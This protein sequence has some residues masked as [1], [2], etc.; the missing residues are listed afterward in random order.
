M[1]GSFPIPVSMM[2]LIAT[3]LISLMAFNAP[4]IIGRYALSPYEVI[5]RGRWDQL[6]TS[7]FLH[8]D[9]GHLFMNMITLYFFGPLMDRV[10]GPAGFTL[11]YFGSMLCGSLLTLAFHHRDPRYRAL[12]ASGAISGV[13]FGFVL[14][15]PMAPIFVF[16]IPIGIPA[17]LFAI[18][19]VLVSVF[20]MRRRWGNIGHEAHLGGAIGGLVLTA[21]LYPGAINIF[22]SHFR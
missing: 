22:L 19:Y 2:I 20:G 5:Q 14:L 11:L 13:L 21:L 17:A 3:A 4:R 6:I 10:L 7:G 16:L 18:L 12:G 9:L 15:R 1:D 8:A